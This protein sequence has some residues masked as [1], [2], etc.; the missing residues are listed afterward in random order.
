MT[1]RNSNANI[2]DSRLDAGYCTIVPVC[3]GDDTRHW[4]AFYATPYGY[5]EMEARQWATSADTWLGFIHNGYQYMR[6][7][8]RFYSRAWAKRLAWEFMR[9]V[10]EGRVGK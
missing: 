5:I 2:T 6:H 9:D 7:F 3:S 10:V 8:D 1:R 4:N